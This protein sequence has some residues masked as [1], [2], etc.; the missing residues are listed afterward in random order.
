V[1][2][3][4][5]AAA[6]SQT[7]ISQDQSLARSI[8][9]EAVDTALR[10]LRRADPVLRG[11]IDAVG[12]F[13]LKLQTR[14]FES[15]ARAI[16][17]QQISGAAARSIWKRLAMSVHPRRVTAES[18]ADLDDLSL[19]T[20][21]VSPQKFSYLRDLQEQVNTKQ[22]RLQRLHLLSDEEVIEELVAI[23]GIGVW[24]AQM[25]LMFS[26]GR[27]DVLP[28]QDLG[29]RAAIKRLYGFAELPNRVE[30]ETIASPWRPYA[31]I[32]CWY[33]WRS[34]DIATPDA[35]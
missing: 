4:R 11:V 20:A 32:A 1:A 9:S 16:V 7:R 21:G 28:H 15:L 10:R 17:A 23:K 31:T 13:G 6:S 25:F 8:S 33:L 19:R 3:K 29:I 34:A 14:R 27:L 5:S 26:L 35:M 18:L 30:C 2:D 24:T 22:V 12:P